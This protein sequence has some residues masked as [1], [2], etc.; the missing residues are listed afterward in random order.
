MRE[1]KDYIDILSVL[2]AFGVITVHVSQ[3]NWYGYIGSFDW[4]VFTVYTSIARVSV[5]II[6][7]LVFAGSYAASSVI[8]KIPKIGRYLA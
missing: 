7:L 5:P 1:R 6:S 4:R 8:M 2:A 3:K